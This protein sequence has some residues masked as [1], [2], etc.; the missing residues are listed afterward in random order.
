VIQRYGNFFL[1]ARLGHFFMSVRREIGL[2]GGG[3]GG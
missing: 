2:F 1:Q 3:V